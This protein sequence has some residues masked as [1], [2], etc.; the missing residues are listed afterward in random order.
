MKVELVCVTPDAEENIVKIARVS[1]S[2]KDK[3]ANSAGLLRYLI[4]NKH[5]SP[6]EHGYMTLE[7]ETSKSIGIQYLRHRSFTFQE[8]SQRYQDVG[9]L[10]EMFEPI[11]LR[12]QATDNRQSSTEV[13]DPVCEDGRLASK[14]VS[15]TLDVCKTAYNLLLKATV[16]RECARFVLPV[17]TR[18]KIYMTGSIRSWIHLIQ[19]RDDGHAQ[20]EAQIIAREAKAIFIEEF[21]VIA[22]ALTL[23]V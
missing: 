20:L 6:F 3:K 10:G 1:S 14:V 5:W 21:P 11:E 12:A 22:D 18:T 2:R 4:T 8:F 17:A 15:D 7:I 23:E 16:A 13:F 19:L 9:V